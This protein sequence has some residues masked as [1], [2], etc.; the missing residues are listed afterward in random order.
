VSYEEEDTCVM[1]SAGSV[2]DLSISPHEVQW[3]VGSDERL[4]QVF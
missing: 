1:R 3:Y 2:A 4:T